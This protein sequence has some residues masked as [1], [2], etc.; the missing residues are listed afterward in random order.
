MDAGTRQFPLVDMHC[1]LDRMTNARDIARGAAK[2]NIAI[3]CTTVTPHDAEL[4]RGFLSDMPNVC[5]GVGLHPWWLSDGRCGTADIERVSQ[6]AA[7]SPYIGEVGL[8]FGKHGAVT[9]A[10]QLEAFGRIARAMAEHP[11]RRR[12]AS[13]HAIRS[14][15]AVLDILEET[16]VAGPGAPAG[17]CCIFH[18]FSGTSDELAR[19]RK[20]G[21]CFS[22]SE[23]ML[24]SKRGREYARQL[25]LDRLLLETDAPPGLDAPYSAE[26]L[27][28]SLTRALAGIAELRGINAAELGPL[29]ARNSLELLE[30]TGWA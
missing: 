16:G 12:V 8:D 22:V 4:A 30:L 13:I 3:F 5:V 15:S 2:R 24:K 19:A 20:L 9:Q 11:L 23:H 18:W 27:E 29:I 26:A 6:L 10:I 21:C 17:T 1:H 7:T 25:P 28:A 14:A